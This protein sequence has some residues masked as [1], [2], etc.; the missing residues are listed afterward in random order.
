MCSSDLAAPAEI[1]QHD[2]RAR[3]LQMA[4][5]PRLG[6]SADECASIGHAREARGRARLG[7]V[8]EGLRHAV[9]DP[10]PLERALHATVRIERQ[11]AGEA[12]ERHRLIVAAQQTL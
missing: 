10:R 1:A 6:G 9:V 2:A 4:C 8:V 7:F 12:F 5:S 3:G 11:R